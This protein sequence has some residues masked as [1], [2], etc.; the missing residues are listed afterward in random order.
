MFIQVIAGTVTD[1]D[2]FQRQADRWETELR[3]GAAGFLGS[4]SGITPDGRFLVMARFASEADARHNSERPEQGKWWAEMEK[5]VRD[6][7]FRDSVEIKEM[8][9]GGSDTA[10]F[11][12][13]MRGHIQDADKLAALETAMVNL[14]TAMRQF[15]PDILGEVIAVHA[16]G[17]YTDA[18]YFTSESAARAG[19]STPPPAELEAVFADMDAAI[20]IDEYLDLTEPTLR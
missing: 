8:F 4:T 14:E 20:V 9:G 7:E 10:G 6:V 15:R 17:T 2:G 18:V 3:P 5:T 1:A 13:V 19:E 16:D 11:V 12:Q